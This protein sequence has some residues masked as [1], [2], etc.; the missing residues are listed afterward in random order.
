MTTHTK[1]EELTL[2]RPLVDFLAKLRFGDLPRVVVLSA[3]SAVLDH[4]ACV[5]YGMDQP[6]VHAVRRAVL[7]P[8]GPAT[9]SG[10]AVVFGTGRRTTPG[11]AALVNGTAAHGFEL[12]DIYYRLHPGSV[13]IPA[14]MASMGRQR[15]DGRDLLTAVTAGYELMGRVGRS[16]GVAHSDRGFHT[17]GVVGPFGAAVGAGRALGLDAEQIHS[18]VGIAASFG[19][20]IKAFAHAPGMVKRLHAG[21]AAKNGV[22]AA[23]LAAAGFEGPERPLEGRFGFCRVFAP[24]DSDFAALSNGLGTEFAIAD[25]YIKPYSCCGALH[26]VIRAAEQLRAGHAID[27]GDIDSVVIGTTDHG[28]QKSQPRPV[29]VMTTQYSLQSAVVLGLRGL[30][31]DPTSFRPDV[32]TTGESGRLLE[33]MD[34]VVDEEAESHFPE[35]LDS[36]V[37]LRL[38]DGRELSAY[39]VGH[40]QGE[41]NLK[42]DQRWN[43][44]L[45]KFDRL[46]DQHLSAAQRK[47]VVSVVEGLAQGATTDELVTVLA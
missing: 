31:G 21:Q 15:R 27:L 29:D 44:A 34:V 30:A 4:L 18:A 33:R 16:I 3:Q 32:V 20:G 40:A 47:Q 23:D 6:W 11:D 13:V 9:P 38:R 25:T 5:T 14:A 37:T 45:A 42:P 26:G 43:T 36:R 41:R 46:T 24:D 22:L 17:M 8:D 2:T 12:D 10:D 28:T 35:S 19:S 39:G 1:T 7:G